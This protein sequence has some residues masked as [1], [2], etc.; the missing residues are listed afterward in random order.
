[1]QYIQSKEPDHLEQAPGE[2]L[3]ARAS[4]LLDNIGW[5]LA[6]SRLFKNHS[7]NLPGFTLQLL[8]PVNFT[9][10]PLSCILEALGG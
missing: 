5:S 7:K 10:L 8:I 1:M 6:S 3:I 2:A 9:F 4:L